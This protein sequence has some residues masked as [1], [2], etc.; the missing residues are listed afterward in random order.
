MLE[1][2]AAVAPAPM[3]MVLEPLATAPDPEAKELGTVYQACNFKYYGLSSPKKDFWFLLND[4][5]YKKHGRGKI[6]GH[7]GEWRPRPQKHRYFILFEK[8]LKILWEE[9]PYPK[10]ANKNPQ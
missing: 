3:A 5:S 8:S 9:S 7:L 10:G 4:G 6:K 1:M 2:L